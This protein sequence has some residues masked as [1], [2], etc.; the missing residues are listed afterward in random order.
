MSDVHQDSASDPGDDMAR[1]IVG[2]IDLPDAL[3]SWVEAEAGGAVVA[4]SR[5]F[6]GASREAWNVDVRGRLE[7][8]ALRPLFLLRD[9]GD[10]E[11]SARDAAVLRALE[12]TAIPVPRVFAQDPHRSTILLERLPGRSDFPAV[13]QESE[14]EPTARHLMELTSALHRL[15]PAKLPIAHLECPATPEDCARPAL[16][17]ARQAQAALGDAADPFFEF[18]LSWLEANVPREQTRYALVHSDMGPGNFLF[19]GGRV[20]GIV[21]WEVAHF[22]DPMEDLAAIAIRDMATPIGSLPRRLAEYA[23]SGGGPVALDRVH[24]YRALLLVRNSLMIGLGLA[25]PAPGFD[26]VEMTMYQTLLMRAAALVLCDNLGVARVDVD[27]AI[28]AF[29]GD[30]SA[31][32]RE[33]LI[34]TLGRDFEDEIRSKLE[35]PES[36]RVGERLS[37]GL[38]ALAHEERVGPALDARESAELRGL[39]AEV[40]AEDSGDADPVERTELEARLRS[41]AGDLGGTRSAK[42]RPKREALAIY[43]AGRM[44]RL[45]ERRRPLMGG[46]H[47]RLPQPL[48]TEEA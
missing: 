45:A 33:I 16:L 12:P 29:D 37:R 47:G 38:A 19:E 14:R 25:Q 15:D 46:L 27:S 24:Y 32:S 20:T 35:A 9:R 22:G 30:R 2:T 48:E 31:G 21:D 44:H 28:P 10:G 17:A 34:R 3:R 8:E 11:G 43:F 4:A 41:S 26:V 18:A 23:A 5:H 13:D 40:G 42:D 36:A 7:H 39:L 1:G 6:A